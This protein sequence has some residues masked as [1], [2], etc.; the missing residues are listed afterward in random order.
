M[1]LHHDHPAPHAA[2]IAALAVEH[3]ATVVSYDSDFVRY[4]GVRWEHP[5]TA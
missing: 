1:R 3:R 4:P 5:A 2:H